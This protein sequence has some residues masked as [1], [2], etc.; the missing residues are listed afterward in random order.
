MFGVAPVLQKSFGGGRLFLAG[1]HTQT[2]FFGFM[3]GALQSG[4]RVAKD[5]I[6]KVCPGSFPN[7]PNV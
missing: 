7:F 4:R 5:V 2:D 3:E 6:S 1:E